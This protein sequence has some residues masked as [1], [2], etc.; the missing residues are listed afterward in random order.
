MNRIS[1]CVLDLELYFY[2]QSPEHRRS[3]F[4]ISFL[5][6]NISAEVGFHSR[7][8]A[9]STTLLAARLERSRGCTS[10]STRLFINEAAVRYSVFN[11]YHRAP[12]ICCT[13]QGTVVDSR[14]PLSTY[15]SPAHNMDKTTA[16]QAHGEEFV[17]ELK[18]YVFPDSKI[19]RTVETGKQP[20]VLVACGSFSPVLLH[21]L[22][23]SET[24]V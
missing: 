3:A 8:I 21:P 18:D 6:M 1:T 9:I 19:K 15:L 2:R 20:I 14:R 13:R 17:G 23:T 7:F 10:T 22:S 12:K 11:N 5:F 24:S 4:S 16:A